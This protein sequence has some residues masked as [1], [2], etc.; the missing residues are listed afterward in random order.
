MTK[1]VTRRKLA[2]VVCFSME[3]ERGVF[4]QVPLQ[5]RV[6]TILRLFFLS[7]RTDSARSGSSMSGKEE[8]N[9]RQNPS[10]NSV[11]QPYQA[12]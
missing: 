2:C 4:D 6:I 1:F 5:H 7:Q 12:T 10:T 9:V 11:D 8:T 3:L